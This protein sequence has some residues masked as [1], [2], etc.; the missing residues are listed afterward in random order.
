LRS[1]LSNELKKGQIM[2]IIRSIVKQFMQ[3]SEIDTLTIKL[4][5]KDMENK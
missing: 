3:G 5:D 1:C 2:S 4:F